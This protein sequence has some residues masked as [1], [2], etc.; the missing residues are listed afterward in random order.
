[1]VPGRKL[2]EYKDLGIILSEARARSGF[3]QEEVLER[4]GL[5]KRKAGSSISHW[6]SGKRRPSALILCHLARLYREPIDPL[7]TLAKYRLPGVSS[8]HWRHMKPLLRDIRKLLKR[9]DNLERQVGKI[10]ESIRNEQ[11][12]V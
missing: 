6:E 9:I 5:D 1:M 7:L 10:S 4:I 8:L 12:G 2:L 11:G 3:T